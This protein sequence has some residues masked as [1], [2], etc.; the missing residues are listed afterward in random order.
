[1]QIAQHTV[2][3]LDYTLSSEDGEVL[4]TSAESEPLSYIHGLGQIVPG[5]ESALAGR[6]VGDALTVHVSAEEGYGVHDPA[7]VHQATRAQFGDAEPEVGMRF[8]AD[9]PDGPLVL[10]V[11]DVE[12]EQIT[13]DGNHPL[14]GVPLT[15]AVT[16]RSVRA[17][18]PQEIEHGHAH[19][20][21][22]HDH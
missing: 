19:G 18:T 20:D 11:V 16:V 17:A 10:T 3:S 4:E 15:F 21:H 2:V 1:M 22:G 14:A 8:Q 12:G 7:L 13:L 9:G 6:I 5:L